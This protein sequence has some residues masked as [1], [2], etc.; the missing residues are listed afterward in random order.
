MITLN[1]LVVEVESEYENEREGIVSNID[2][3]DTFFITRKATVVSAPK[4]TILKKGDTVVC[5]H[6][7]FR[8]KGSTSG[9]IIHSAFH[10]EDNLYHVPLD[11]VFM[12]KR[13]G[14]DWVS[15]S[16]FCFVTPIKDENFNHLSET[17]KQFETHKGFKK[18]RGILAYPCKELEQH[19]NK[20]VIFSNDSEY[21]FLIDGVLYYKMKLNDILIFIE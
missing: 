21:E 3:N 17:E 11:E 9:T 5:H 12:F 15:L 18:N 2:Y 16:P 7:I 20:E 14:E 8:K 1:C 6:N 10:I 13:D 19:K 4:F